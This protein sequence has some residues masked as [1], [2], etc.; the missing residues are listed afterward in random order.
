MLTC[1]AIDDEPI[2][3][4]I[5]QT[6][7]ERIPFLELKATFT[8]PRKALD[9]LRSEPVDLVFLDVNMPVFNGL[10]VAEI[11]RRQTAV[12]F[13]TAYPEYAL[14]GYE[15]EVADYLLKPIAFDRFLQATQKIRDR[16]RS[17]S[18][19]A[20]TPLFVKD[21]YEWV[22]IQPHLIQYLES[23]DNYVKI[24]QAHQTIL[25]RSSYPNC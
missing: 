15:L 14:K 21:G 4:E 20:S 8:N 19:V 18:V 1:L 12:I 10:E 22:G 5:I 2:A 25:I 23:A 6:F 16:N 3:L 24:C 13:T 9:F 7:A 11:L 17:C